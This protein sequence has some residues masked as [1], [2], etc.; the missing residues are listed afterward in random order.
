VNARRVAA[1]TGIPVALR[2]RRP[3][4]SKHAREGT[5]TSTTVS[6]AATEANAGIDC[7]MPAEVGRAHIQVVWSSKPNVG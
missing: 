1:L 6:P 5:S 7:D 4:G 2:T 3:R